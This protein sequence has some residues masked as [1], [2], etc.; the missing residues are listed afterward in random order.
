MIHA[1]IL[2]SSFMARYNISMDFNKVSEY[3]ETEYP[4]MNFK[5]KK[6][7]QDLQKVIQQIRPKYTEYHNTKLYKDD[8]CSMWVHVC[9]ATLEFGV[10]PVKHVSQPLPLNNIMVKKLS[11]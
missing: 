5:N 1:F 3:P 7:I 4:Y 6:H 2:R 8:H 11:D 9:E 10:T